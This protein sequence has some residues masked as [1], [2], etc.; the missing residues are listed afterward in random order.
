MID[1][2]PYGRKVVID[3]NLTD[4][5]NRSLVK[6]MGLDELLPD[7]RSAVAYGFDHDDLANGRIMKQHFQ[8]DGKGNALKLE[9]DVGM[10]RNYSEEPMIMDGLL[11]IG[12]IDNDDL[13]DGWIQIKYFQQDGKWKQDLSLAHGDVIA[14]VDVAEK[15]TDD[16][17]DKPFPM[18]GQ[19]Q[20][21]IVIKLL[22]NL[23]MLKRSLQRRDLS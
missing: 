13:A 16:R 17:Q 19:C 15:P 5:W 12:R 10:V 1:D 22:L 18:V 21:V 6:S 2:F 4:G 14:R 20:K 11:P 3:D 23:K 8:E 7:G 9:Y